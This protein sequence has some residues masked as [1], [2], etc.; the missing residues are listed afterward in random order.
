LPKWIIERCA[1]ASLAQSDRKALSFVFLFFITCK[2]SILCRLILANLRGK[3][4]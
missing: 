4:N 3:I 1:G 2:M